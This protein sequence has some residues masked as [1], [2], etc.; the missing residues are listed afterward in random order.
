MFPK[1][2][3]FRRPGFEITEDEHTQKVADSRELKPGKVKDKMFWLKGSWIM[4]HFSSQY[5]PW[6]Y[7]LPYIY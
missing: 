4:P 3:W 2:Q 7:T 5:Q 1:L 6:H